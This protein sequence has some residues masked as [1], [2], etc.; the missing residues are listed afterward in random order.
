SVTPTGRWADG[1][2]TLTL[3]VED[4]GA[5]VKYSAPLTVTV[6]TQISIGVIGLVNDKGIPG[7]NLTNDVR[8]NFRVT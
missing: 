3:R 6:D 2:Y 4:D 1:D 7:H 5:N 8:P